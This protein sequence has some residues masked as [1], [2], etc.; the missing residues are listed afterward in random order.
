MKESV[1][2]ACPSAD[3]HAVSTAEPAYEDIKMPKNTSVGLFIAGFAFAFGFAMIWHI[4]W[5]ALCGVVAIIA[6]VIIRSFNED[7]EYTIT[8]AEVAEIERGY[9]TI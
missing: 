1:D 2:T 3:G 4:W 7:I 8:A 5:L 6:S 9:K